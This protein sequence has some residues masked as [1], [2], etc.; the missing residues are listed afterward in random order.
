MPYSQNSPDDVQRLAV[1]FIVARLTDVVPLP[2]LQTFQSGFSVQQG[3]PLAIVEPIGGGEF[4]YVTPLR[5][6]PQPLRLLPVP[7]QL[8]GG[9]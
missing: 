5:R 2:V 7:A 6:H 4:R 3:V 9:Q 1:P 8:P